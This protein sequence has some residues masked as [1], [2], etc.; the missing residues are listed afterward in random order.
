MSPHR[1]LWHS[2]LLFILLMTMAKESASKLLIGL[3]DNGNVDLRPSGRHFVVGEADLVEAVCQ[4]QPG[5]PGGGAAEFTWLLNGNQISGKSVISDGGSVQFGR[6]ALSEPANKLECFAR[7]GDAFR[8]TSYAF[9]LLV[10]HDAAYADADASL[11]LSLIEG[12]SPMS[13]GA[14]VSLQCKVELSVESTD[15]AAIRNRFDEDDFRP[16]FFFALSKSVYVDKRCYVP[17][18]KSMC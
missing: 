13:E 12:E 8:T 18:S 7:N 17:M 4:K 6:E 2:G 16:E 1:T 5:G 9:A 14:R 15:A 11:S 3:V 10:T